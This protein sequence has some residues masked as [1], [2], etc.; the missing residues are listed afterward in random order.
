M[1]RAIAERTS[2]VFRV[3]W[4]QVGLMQWS[5]AASAAAAKYVASRRA[6]SF[7][8]GAMAASAWAAVVAFA[9]SN[10]EYYVIFVR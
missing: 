4:S 5:G 7:K 1:A 3:I 6:P 9:T 8:W 10:N 2:P